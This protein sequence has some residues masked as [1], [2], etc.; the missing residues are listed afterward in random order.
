MHSRGKLCQEGNAGPGAA[1][2]CTACR[3]LQLRALPS[4][5]PH[6]FSNLPLLARTQ[7]AAYSFNLERSESTGLVCTLLPLTYGERETVCQYVLTHVPMNLIACTLCTY[8]S[9]CVQ[10]HRT[11]PL[12]VN[13]CPILSHRHS[14]VRPA[15]P[16]WHTSR[17]RRRKPGPC[18]LPS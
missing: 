8:D 14:R 4:L 1:L 17:S 2:A 13:T 3:I 15:W 7:C 9:H 18:T 6:N 12:T 16:C 10:G 5:H 11:H